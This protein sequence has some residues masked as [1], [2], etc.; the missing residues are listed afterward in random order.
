MRRLLSPTSALVTFFAGV[1][2]VAVWVEV[3]R[4]RAH[5]AALPPPSA[6]ALSPAAESRPD[7]EKYA[8]YSALLKDMYVNDGI[9]LL[10]IGTADH[11]PKT[12]DEKA[13]DADA[14]QMASDLG[15]GLPGL[16]RA[17]VEDFVARSNRC[18][19][20]GR[21]F[22]LPVDYVLVTRKEL[23]RLFGRG[24]VG[25]GWE[26][27]YKKYPGSAGIISLSNVGF[28]AAMD[29]ALVAPSK[30]CGGLCGAG[31]YVLLAKRDGVWRVQS[32]SMT[33]VS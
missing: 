23:D 2:A 6:P 19:P 13:P 10:V 22:E 30:G 11:C 32:K 31:Y 18:E 26:R 1:F 12:P 28:N 25:G 14:E 16:E 24:D 17:T 7:A 3:S 21:R 29:Q 5:T 27:F 4:P 20:L 8:V 15:N 33:W 9:K